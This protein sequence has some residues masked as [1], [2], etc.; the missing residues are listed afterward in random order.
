[1]IKNR[2]PLRQK[3]A[4]LSS[5]NNYYA[6]KGEVLRQVD[7]ILEPSGMTTGDADLPNDEGRTTVPIVLIEGRQ[8]LCEEV[9]TLCYSWYRMPSGRYE[10][11]LYIA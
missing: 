9:G 3:I 6:T 5:T 1:M 8:H 7:A 4:S 11:T 10:A 2:D